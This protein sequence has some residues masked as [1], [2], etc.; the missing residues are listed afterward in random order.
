[1][2]DDRLE[3]LI[4]APAVAELSRSFGTDMLGAVQIFR[5]VRML[6]HR[7]NEANSNWLAPHQLTPAQYN[8][9]AV[10]FMHGR[11]VGRVVARCRQIAAHD[12]RNRDFNDRHA[13]AEWTHQTGTAPERSAQHRPEAHAQRR[14]PVRRSRSHA[15]RARRYGD[16]RLDE[17]RNAD[18]A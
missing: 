6:S 13:G 2:A 17:R 8:F 18:A 5:A 12:E 14:K 9:L 10:L 7:M 15:S 16:A 3:I 4:S 1:M 11:K